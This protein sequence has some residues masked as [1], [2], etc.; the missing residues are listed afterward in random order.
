MINN[1]ETSLV[2]SLRIALIADAEYCCPSWIPIVLEKAKAHGRLTTKRVYG[3]FD[4]PG[5]APWKG[6]EINRL[7]LNEGFEKRMTTRYCT[8]KNSSDLAIAIGAMDIFHGE[9]ADELWLIGG[10]RDYAQLAFRFQEDNFPFRVFGPSNTSPHLRAVCT[11]FEEI[12]YQSS[13]AAATN[14]SSSPKTPQL[15]LKDEPPIASRTGK[16]SYLHFFGTYGFV[17][18]DNGGA[19]LFFHSSELIKCEFSDLKYWEA[20]SY[21]IG[22]NSRGPCAISLRLHSSGTEIGPKNM[23]HHTHAVS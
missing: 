8:R 10:D 18:Q 15:R 1:A 13:L 14:V 6:R 21:E 23:A 22:T 7:L 2:R 5:M 11:S 17:K 3:D 12:N 9:L 20:V 16:I 19:D 4:A